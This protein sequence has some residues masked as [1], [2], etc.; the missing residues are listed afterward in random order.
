MAQTEQLSA[1]PALYEEIRGRT[2]A[3]KSFVAGRRTLTYGTLFDQVARSATLFGKLGLAP[4]DRAIIASDDDLA[5]ITLFLALVRT[6]VTAVILNPEATASELRALIDAADAKVLFMDPEI[7]R[8]A[9]LVDRAGRGA[10]VI[11]IDPAAAKPKSILGRLSGGTD[12]EGAPSFPALL[13]ALDPAPAL[14]DALPDSTAAYILFTSGTTSRPKGVEI[15]HRNLFA[16]MATFRRQYGYDAG[17]RL[18]NILPL[19]HT[20]GLTQ[21]PVV[22][23]TCGA[24]VHRPLRF[25]VDLL[26]DLLDCIYAERI[27]H[28]I[29]VPAVLTLME[30]LAGDH[31]DCF[32][33]EDFRFVISTAAY[34]D[35]RLWAD[36]E[37]RFR[38]MVVNVY[39]LTET[40]C[41]A[42]YCGPDEATRKVG[43]VGKPVDGAARIVGEDG[44]E[45]APGATGEL[46]LKGDHV[47]AG[48]FRMPEETAAVLKDGW[49]HTG[50]LAQ[51]DA[52]GFY[53]IVGRKKDVIVSAGINI[54]PE[55]VTNVLRGLPGVLDAATLGVAD[56]TWGERVV[57]CVVPVPDRDLSVEALTAQFLE[58]ASREKLPKE[59]HIVSDLPRGPAGKVIA[60]ELR[61]LVLRQGEQAAADA[62]AGDLEQ[63]LFQ[64]AAETFQTPRDGLSLGSTPENTKG[65]SSL[66]HVE[67][68]L[69]IEKEFD[70]RMTP[71]EIMGIKSIRDAVQ[72]V[73]AKLAGA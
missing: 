71:Q 44:A 33:T 57:A 37:T 35:A 21:G 40:V 24:T 69:A 65:W 63:R 72:V 11:E 28:F 20:D 55:D 29:T 64:R 46:L 49:F 48:Y 62:D 52:E 13:E 58:Q 10:T 15:S 14:P 25:R 61:E 56:D 18:L 9:G 7:A 53:S 31:Q 30:T 8:R 68:L 36:F 38:V 32:E 22:A 27:T 50:D 67:L 4:G 23:F 26:P 16:Q 3:S 12:A 66:A 54:H 17:A 5:T 70:I 45:A 43:T 19:H 51:V 42:L 34:L 60:S 1:F 47:M 73:E 6:G 59:I 39:G 2:K 41:E